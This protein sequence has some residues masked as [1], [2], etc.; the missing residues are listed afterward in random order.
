MRTKQHTR[1]V[2]SGKNTGKR[3]APA[4]PDN[5][6]ARAGAVEDAKKKRRW[7]PG[8]AA[9]HRGKKSRKNLACLI[10]K[11]IINRKIRQFLP[12]DITQLDG[13]VSDII[14]AVSETLLDH[15]FFRSRAAMSLRGVIGI[16]PKILAH[17]WLT[18]TRGQ[19]HFF[20]P[21]EGSD[22]PH[23]PLAIGEKPE[24]YFHRLSD[25]VTG[26]V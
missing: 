22:F 18:W 4:A 15:L 7:R 21:P 2:K 12:A 20:F 8:T 9:K 23:A 19:P 14:R 1:L 25:T 17:E 26:G 24:A 6:A 11:A 3:K 16:T 13:E 5:A 10:P